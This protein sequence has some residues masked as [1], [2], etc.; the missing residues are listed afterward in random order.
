M[1]TLI[2]CAGAPDPDLSVLA[3]TPYQQLIG[4]DAGADRLAQA[5][6]MP[7]CAV[8]DFDS[9]PPPTCAEILRLPAEKDDTDLEA[10][11]MHI[12]P[13]YQAAELK[14]ILILGALGGGRLDHL[15]ANV[16]LAHQARFAPYLP[17]LHFIERHNSLRFLNS[18]SHCIRRERNHSYL[19]FIGLTPLR[20]LS[21][22]GV[23]YPL[24]QADYSH[25]TAL[26]SNE[27]TGGGAMHCTLQNGL[28]AVIQSCDPV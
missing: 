1:T 19:S 10:A 8:G 13:R 21:L 5:G 28:L 18:G 9:A 4:V 22:A 26:I 16:W 14:R 17:L 2:F 7:D 27:F 3:H 24:H 23:K 25:P 11:L 6:F 20:G 12:L 15:L